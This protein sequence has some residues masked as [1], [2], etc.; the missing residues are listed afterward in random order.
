MGVILMSNKDIFDK[1]ESALISRK[2]NYVKFLLSKKSLFIIFIIITILIYKPTEYYIFFITGL[3]IFHLI[4]YSNSNVKY[5][6]PYIYIDDDMSK[7]LIISDYLNKIKKNF[8][9]S[10]LLCFITMSNNNLLFASH[11]SKSIDNGTDINNE[12][13]IEQELDINLFIKYIQNTYVIAIFALQENYF[14]KEIAKKINF[15]NENLLLENKFLQVEEI[16]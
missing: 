7:E 16:K 4:V 10:I 6:E 14:N 13:N 15:E 11:M 9:L 5:I 3:V 12:I 1:F 8:L 2:I